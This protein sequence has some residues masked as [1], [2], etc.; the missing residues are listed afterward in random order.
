MIC[1]VFVNIVS[2]ALPC[3][4]LTP[5]LDIDRPR[6]SIQSESLPI[7]Q[8][9]CKDI[10]RSANFK[11]HA[12]RAGTMYCTSRNQVMIMFFRRYLVHILLSIE[13]NLSSLSSPQVLYHLVLIHSV[14]HAEINH[15]FICSIEKIVAFIL[16]IR[17]SHILSD[18]LSGRMHLKTEVTSADCIK[19]VETYRKIFAESRLHDFPEHFPA[20]AENKIL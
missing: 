7:P 5:P 9:K 2:I 12:A 17:H 1:K 18:K 4:N 10:R 20:L 6:P 19:K 15:R 16:G 8:F 13:D 14:F 3:D 11:H